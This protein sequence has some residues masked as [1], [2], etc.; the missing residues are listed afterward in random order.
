MM[1]TFNNLATLT[2]APTLRDKSAVEMSRTPLNKPTCSSTNNNTVSLRFN[3]TLWGTRADCAKA[4][5]L[6]PKAMDK[7]AVTPP[8]WRVWERVLRFMTSFFRVGLKASRL[9]E[10]SL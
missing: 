3:M 4:S 10:P 6:A 7:T 8:S 1:G 9:S 2:K 5:P